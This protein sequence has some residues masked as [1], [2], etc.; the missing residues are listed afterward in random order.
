MMRTAALT[1]QIILAMAGIFG[2][3]IWVGRLTSAPAADGDRPAVTSAIEDERLVFIMN[4]YREQLGLRPEQMRRLE[5]VF[6]AS[7]QDIQS[8]R[9]RSVARME[10]ITKFHD[11]IEPELDDRQREKAREMLNEVRS[12]LD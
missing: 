2:L 10:E 8:T 7:Q 5:P 1:L 11:R 12:K 4:R 9:P 3:G 6:R